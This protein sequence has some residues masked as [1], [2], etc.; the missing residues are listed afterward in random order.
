M[1][2][3]TIILCCGAAAILLAGGGWLYETLAPA[4]HF[5]PEH[6]PVLAVPASPL[7]SA[8]RAA[9]AA[10]AA[11]GGIAASTVPGGAEA[12]LSDSAAAEPDG[13]SPFPV[14]RGGGQERQS[15]GE[16]NPEAGSGFNMLILGV[17]GRGAGASRSDVIIV[18]HFDPDQRQVNLVSVPRDTQVELPGVGQT[19]VNHAHFLGELRGGDEEGTTA[20]IAAVSTLLQ[21]PI[22]YYVK[23]DFRGFAGAIDE[24]GGV[25]V[26]LPADMLLSGTGKV[27]PAGANHLDGELA[28]Q[29]VRERYSLSGGDFDRQ[30]DQAALLRAAAK[31]LLSAERLPS[32][33]GLARTLGSYVETN[34]SASDMASLALLFKDTDGGSIRHIAIP[35]KAVMEED[36][37]IGS[38][39]WYWSADAKEVAGISRE[40][41]H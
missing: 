1:K 20:A 9:S 23:T 34:L 17:D 39:L 2:R 11:S 33:P 3:K 15:A 24:I 18:A 8:S 40:Y 13:L 37:L 31:K 35:G 38:R 5:R 7:P 16:R 29:F 22:H 21:V 19:K 28:L 4:R 25:D 14:S 27:L 6:L 30:A 10:I 41:L 26:T 12:P 32:L 36:P